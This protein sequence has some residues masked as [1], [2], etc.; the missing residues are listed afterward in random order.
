MSNDTIEL[1]DTCL[2]ANVLSLDSYLPNAKK[3][4]NKQLLLL[5]KSKEEIITRNWMSKWKNKNI[6]K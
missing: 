5:N 1:T 6:I 2:N 3:S 4:F